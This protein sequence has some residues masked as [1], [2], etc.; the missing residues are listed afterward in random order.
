MD[1]EILTPEEQNQLVQDSLQENGEGGVIGENKSVPF[2]ENSQKGEVSQEAPGLQGDELPPDPNADFMGYVQWLG[3]KTQ[4][5]QDQAQPGQT[6]LDQAQSGQAQQELAQQE[7]AQA[8]D[9][10]NTSVPSEA[11]KL[12]SFFNQSV[13]T[14]KHKHHDFDQAADFVYD[15]RAKQ[16]ASCAS[17]YPER[18]NPKVIDTLIGNEL[19][20]I[21]RDCAQNK[22]NPAQ[23][24]YSIAQNMGYTNKQGNTVNIVA[25]MQNTVEHV[26]ERQNSART[27][28]AYNGL[29]PKGPMS[30][31]MLDKMSEAEFSTWIDDPNNKT[32]FNRLMGDVD[33]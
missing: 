21:L 10:Q 27:L 9:N 15:M 19:K 33:L 31:E 32:A 8:Q 20:Q 3:K 18:A 25:P 30:L 26:Q 17:L 22:Q 12:R 28:S 5:Q 23:V 16:L 29:N 4:T 7:L 24:I 6:R 2:D 1:E 11:E 13:A 14:I